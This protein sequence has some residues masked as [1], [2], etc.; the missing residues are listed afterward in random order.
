MVGSRA[1]RGKPSSE[2]AHLLSNF[3]PFAVRWREGNIGESH[4]A[5]PHLRNVSNIPVAQN[6]SVQLLSGILKLHRFGPL[7]MLTPKKS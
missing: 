6:A 7:Q 4:F 5:A 3:K 2:P 1:K